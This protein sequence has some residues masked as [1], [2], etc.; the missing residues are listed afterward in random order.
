MSSHTPDYFL[1]ERNKQIE[2][3]RQAI[4]CG[5]PPR[6]QGGRHNRILL[7][8]FIGR[9]W[10]R[11]GK[12][13]SPK[14]GAAYMHSAPIHSP[15]ATPPHQACSFS[16]SGRQGHVSTKYGLVYTASIMVHLC[17]SQWSWLFSGV[18][19]SQVQVIRLSCSPGRHLGTAATPAPHNKWLITRPKIV[20]NIFILVGNISIF[21]R[22]EVPV[23]QPPEL[24]TT[25]S[26]TWK[27][28]FRVLQSTAG[29]SYQTLHCLRGIWGGAQFGKGFLLKQETW[30]WIPSGHIESQIQEQQRDSVGRNTCHE[31]LSFD[32]WN[33]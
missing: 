7:H 25:R 33:P 8:T 27:W 17:S 2:I 26:W 12:T 10:E 29:C 23:H 13:P 1:K 22:Q 11:R 16:Q 28:P 19:G 31:N 21:I 4:G 5:R 15:Q 24:S 9:A 6:Q 3:G 30:V 32:P 20:Q 14:T 18:W